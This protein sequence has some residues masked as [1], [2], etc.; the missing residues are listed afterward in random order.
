MIENILW[1]SL[2][3]LL[4]FVVLKESNRR[5]IVGC[6]GWVLFSVY[7]LTTVEHYIEIGDFFNVV[8]VCLMT[9]FCILLAY[10]IKTYS[11]QK[12]ET[13]LLVTKVTALTCIIYFP[14]ANI[15]A[16]NSAIIGLTAMITNSIL[17]FFG[18]P[19]KL[20]SPYI[21]QGNLKIEI[22]LACTA[23]E[24]MA[25]FSGVV[26]GVKAPKNRKFKAFM[27]SVP[28]I[29]VLNLVRN[30]TVTAAY[31]NSL[32]G[33]PERTFYIAHHILAKIGSTIALIGI[34]YA[35]FMIQPEVLNMIEDLWYLL[36]GAKKKEDKKKG[37]KNAN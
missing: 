18:V 14:F 19:T 33:S 10:Y 32:F 20:S 35:V 16:L 9:G 7:W 29:Y 22:I 4:L 12:Y 15:D 5:R 2:L 36:S 30:V 37:D 1:I 23:I 8:L 27:V 17:N 11:G 6:I 25:L 34:A 31:V 13:L 24:S 26:L 3:F 28:V 21:Y